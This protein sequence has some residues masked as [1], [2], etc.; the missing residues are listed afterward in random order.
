MQAWKISQKN[1]KYS[2]R[3]STYQIAHNLY[4]NGTLEYQ[5][6][7]QICFFLQI[8]D[9]REAAKKVIKIPAEEAAGLLAL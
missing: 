3:I 4:L 6:S 9:G 7:T 1:K 8:F 5:K 2:S